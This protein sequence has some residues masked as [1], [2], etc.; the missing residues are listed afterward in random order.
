MVVAT[1]VHEESSD[2]R[3]EDQS[4]DTDGEDGGQQM[5]ELECTRMALLKIDTS[6]ATVVDLPEEFPEV[7]TTFVPYP[8][9]GKETWLIA[10]L[11]DTIGEVDVL[12]KT[13][14]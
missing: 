1:V 3:D 13:H 4:D 2:S 6:D 12:T 8:G 5:Y 9:F 11:D 7:G 10:C 14:L